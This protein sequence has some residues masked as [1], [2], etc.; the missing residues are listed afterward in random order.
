MPGFLCTSVPRVLEQVK[1]QAHDE[2]ST[3]IILVIGAG[4]WRGRGPSAAIVRSLAR[5]LTHL[6]PS[7]AGINGAAGAGWGTQQPRSQSM[8]GC[9]APPP[10]RHA[11][12]F[13]ERHLPCE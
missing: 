10:S 1:T 2:P 4:Q 12:M 6:I 9:L 13:S 3:A 11:W 5:I 8:W 7:A